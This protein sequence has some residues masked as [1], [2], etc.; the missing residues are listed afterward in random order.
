[1]KVVIIVE[2]GMVQ[3]VFCSEKDVEIEVID[4]DSLDFDTPSCENWL[5][6]LY[7]VY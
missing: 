2:S 1:M 4:L 3:S 7:E 6:G 5:E